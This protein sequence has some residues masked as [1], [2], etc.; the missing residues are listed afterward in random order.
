L[1]NLQARPIGL[2]AAE[3]AGP[4]LQV[5]VELVVEVLVQL[6]EQQHLA[7][8]ILVAVAAGLTMLEPLAQA[9]RGLSTSVVE[10]LVLL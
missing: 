7:P 4:A 2:V 1:D 6:Q 3:E 8:Q 10:S 9:V 5:L